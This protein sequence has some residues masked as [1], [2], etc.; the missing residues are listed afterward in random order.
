[1]GGVGVSEEPRWYLASGESSEFRLSPLMMTTMATPRAVEDRSLPT[2]IIQGSTYL[3]RKETLL[4][5][6]KRQ[7]ENFKVQSGPSGVLSSDSVS[8]GEP[9]EF[10]NIE[11]HKFH[12]PEAS[13]I[14]EIII[15]RNWADNFQGSVTPESGE[16]GN[17]H[18]T[19]TTSDASIAVDGCWDSWGLLST[20][21]W[22]T[23]PIIMEIF[24][25]RFADEKAERDFC[26]VRRH[27]LS[28]QLAGL[29]AVD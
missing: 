8:T 23:W 24:S 5:A 16:N 2:P 12:L 13:L 6:L 9:D 17:S 20:L 10:Q 15:D 22:R 18:P 25:L 7:W 21:R 4:N 26:Q 29:T 14:N 3:S 11:E 27:V 1:M 19:H 28:S